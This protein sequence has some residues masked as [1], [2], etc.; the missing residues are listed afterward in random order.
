MTKFITLTLLIS[1]FQNSC[2][3]DPDFKVNFE[4]TTKIVMEVDSLKIPIDTKIV[5]DTDYFS[6]TPEGEYLI[7]FGGK[8]IK[9]LDLLRDGYRA[10]LIGTLKIPIGVII[11]SKLTGA[12]Y[13]IPFKG[14]TKLDSP[15]R[16]T[17][18][19]GRFY[20]IESNRSSLGS[21]GDTL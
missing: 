1:F 5:I 3:R 6:E 15:R 16:L 7:K 9:D 4:T 2:G 10:S 17:K 8:A 14:I 13:L 12:Y 11:Y 18:I 21:Y 20:K 19:S